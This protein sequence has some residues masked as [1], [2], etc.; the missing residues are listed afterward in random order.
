MGQGHCLHNLPDFLHPQLR[1]AP[2]TIDV[3]NMVHWDS[4]SHWSPPLGHFSGPLQQTLR[5][6]VE[7]PHQPAF[8]HHEQLQDGR[9]ATPS[10][11]TE[12]QSPNN[13]NDHKQLVNSFKPAAGP[14][15]KSSQFDFLSH[16]QTEKPEPGD[17]TAAHSFRD[18]LTCRRKLLHPKQSLTGPPQIHQPRPCRLQHAEHAGLNTT[19]LCLI[20]HKHK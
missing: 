19:A 10:R 15:K 20:Q 16:D 7:G 12:L 13:T 9:E 3:E 17:R 14:E 2:E 8:S 1:Q 5:R 6:P 18:P 11:G 4:G